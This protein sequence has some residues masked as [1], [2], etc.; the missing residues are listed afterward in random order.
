MLDADVA[1]EGVAA[2]QRAHLV[3]ARP[4]HGYPARVGQREPALSPVQQDHRP[5]GELTGQ[6]PQSGRV[7][8][9]R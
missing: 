5:F 4:D 3:G 9:H 1:G 7:Q 2:Q 6:L 8:V